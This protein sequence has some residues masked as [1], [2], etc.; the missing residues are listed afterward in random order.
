MQKHST[1]EI[2]QRHDSG[3]ELVFVDA[4]SADSWAKADQ[5]IPNSLRVP[6]DDVDKFTAAIP[7]DA[8]IIT[9]CT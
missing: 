5:Q 3:E 2:K 4:R 7:K 8:T 6:P 1:E 9:Y